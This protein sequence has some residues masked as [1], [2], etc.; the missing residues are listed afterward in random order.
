MA[1]LRIM[2]EIQYAKARKAKSDMICSNL[3]KFAE[4]CWKA[5]PSDLIKCAYLPK[6]YVT[7]FTILDVKNDYKV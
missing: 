6:V 5:E 1:K 3:C 2:V 7:D 4:I